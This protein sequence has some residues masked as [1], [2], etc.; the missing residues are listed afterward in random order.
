MILCQC[1]YCGHKFYTIPAEIKRGRG[2]CCSHK[3][4]G[5]IKREKQICRC[6]VCNEE[7]YRKPSQIKNGNNKYCSR[8]CM[9]IRQ[10]G[11]NNPNFGNKW[12]EEMKQKLSIKNNKG[13]KLQR[14]CLNCGKEFIVYSCILGNGNGNFCSKKCKSIGKF[15]SNWRG[16]IEHEPYTKEFNDKLREKI[17][18]RDNCTCQLCGKHQYEFK[19]KLTVHHINYDK[20]NSSE[21]NLIALCNACNLKVNYK[22]VFWTGYFIGFI[23]RYII[24]KG[25]QPNG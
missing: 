17:R 3:C 25:E 2:K 16:G 11:E 12:S 23:N 4:A 1:K 20:K 19:S 22:R 8:K 6:I 15:N 14:V 13:K 5:L 21:E 9:S 18:E 10:R 7:F 24:K